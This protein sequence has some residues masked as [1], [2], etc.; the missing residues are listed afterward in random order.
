[1]PLL[2]MF[3]VMD[4]VYH[5]L[6]SFF[7]PENQTGT[8][9]MQAHYALKKLVKHRRRIVK[10]KRSLRRNRF[11]IKENSEESVGSSELKEYFTRSEFP[12]PITLSRE[13][14]T[15]PSINLLNRR[16]LQNR[17]LMSNARQVFQIQWGCWWQRC[18]L[19]LMTAT[20][21]IGCGSSVYCHSLLGLYDEEESDPPIVLLVCFLRQALKKICNRT[22]L[23]LSSNG[24]GPTYI[25]TSPAMELID[26]RDLFQH[27]N[28]ALVDYLLRVDESKSEP[29]E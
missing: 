10:S 11:P 12:A 6:R 20:M 5:G 21:Q 15:T 19:T 22:D 8:P 17:P 9:N 2:E 4:N 16:R 26:I 14:A 13:P 27:I 29:T 25:N 7:G 24:H 28:N 18:W 23:A 1:M 3:V